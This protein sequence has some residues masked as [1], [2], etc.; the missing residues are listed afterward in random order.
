MLFFTDPARTP[1]PL[2]VVARLPRGAGVV[3]RAFG[4]AD[5]IRTGRALAKT[6]RRRGVMMLVGADA[7]LA[8][9]LK[10]DGLHLPERLAAQARRYRGRFRVTAAAHSL[11]AA[12]TARRAG[13]EAVVVSPV[14]P[15]RSPSAR[16]P[17][18]PRRLAVLVRRARTPVYA[19]GG[20]KAD[21]AGKLAATGVVGIAAVEGLTLGQ[22]TQT[23][24]M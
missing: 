19:L 11:P 10:A 4:A 12:L 23:P 14:F 5:A 9:R 15:S 20:V 17:I 3:F 1:D 2:S 22:A 8:A 6:C 7:R 21:N 24:F 18:G 16:R 13:A